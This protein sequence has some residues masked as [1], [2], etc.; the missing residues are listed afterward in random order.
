MKKQVHPYLPSIIL[1][2]LMGCGKSTIGKELHRE[3]R[4]PLRDTD[5]M[6]ERGEG[7]S[8]ARIFELHGEARFRDL[9]TALLRRLEAN[10]HI[11][12]IVSTGGGIA[13][14]PENRAILKNMGFVVW[15]DSDAGTLY[16]R[17]R[18]CT[19]R[20]LLKNPDPKGT[21]ERLLRE[22]NDFYKET[23]H[24]RIDTSNLHINEITY[25]ILESAQVFL[26]RGR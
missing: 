16:K 22:R 26:R 25:G 3:T 23:A 2:G 6:I 18:H 24:L 14:R 17:I 12:G 7:M 10:K 5:Q 19:N 15:L 4:L 8:I 21:L 9:E 1:I 13:I 11:P 20:P